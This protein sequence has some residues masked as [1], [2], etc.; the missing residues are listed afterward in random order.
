MLSQH[1]DAHVS[2]RAAPL[3]PPPLLGEQP[4][5]ALQNP[6][7]TVQDALAQVRLGDLRREAAHPQ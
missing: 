4:L 6:R 2:P 5:L 1:A 3:S 7:V